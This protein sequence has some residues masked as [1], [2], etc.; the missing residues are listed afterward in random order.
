MS[1]QEIASRVFDVLRVSYPT[2][3]LTLSICYLAQ[4]DPHLYISSRIWKR[5]RRSRFERMVDAKD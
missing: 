5:V 4:M 2:E 1:P 3:K